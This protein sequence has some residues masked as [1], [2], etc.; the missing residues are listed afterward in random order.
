MG[1][2]NGN[3]C[4]GKKYV[5]SLFLFAS[6]SPTPTATTISAITIPTIPPDVTTKGEKNYTQQLI[7]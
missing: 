7:L 2:L 1:F 3:F 4:S 5:P 6:A